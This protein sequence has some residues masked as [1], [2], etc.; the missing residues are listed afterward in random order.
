MNDKAKIVL[1]LGLAMIAIQVI[2]EWPL[3][4][5]VVFG[6]GAT[7]AGSAGR[8]AGQAGNTA[9]TQIQ[10]TNARAA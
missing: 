2:K 4:V 8:A 10:R 1:W 5:S 3:I 6:G 7:A 9:A